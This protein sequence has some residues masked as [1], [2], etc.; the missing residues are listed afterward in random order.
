MRFAPA[1]HGDLQAR[2]L[3]EQHRNC[4]DGHVRHLLRGHPAAERQHGHERVGGQAEHL[5]EFALAGVLAAHIVEGII[6]CDLCVGAWIPG[7][8]IDTVDDSGQLMRGPLE[9]A[10]HQVAEARRE[11]FAR[12]GFADGCYLIRVDDAGFHQAQRAVEL[13]AFGFGQRG[14]EPLG[15]DAERCTK[16]ERVVALEGQIVDCENTFRVHAGAFHQEGGEAGMPVVG[17]DDI[18]L[19]DAL[20]A[21]CDADCGG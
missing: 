9:H 8:G 19:L 18:G 10:F 7:G 12:V 6:A 3:C 2:M 21:L 4:G 16:R 17:V 1:D 14:H 11:D 5:L 15:G 20:D 13:D